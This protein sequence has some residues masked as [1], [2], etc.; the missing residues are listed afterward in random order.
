MLF[1]RSLSKL[2][3]CSLAGHIA[4]GVTITLIMVWLKATEESSFTCIGRSEKA[5]GWCYSQY[6]TTY[7]SPLPYI[8]FILFNFVSVYGTTF[9]FSILTFCCN[10]YDDKKASGM[11]LVFQLLLGALFTFLQHGIFFPKWFESQF[12]CTFPS[13]E[14]Q[15]E[16]NYTYAICESLTAENKDAVMV[17]VSMVNVVVA[18]ISLYELTRLLRRENFQLLITC[19]QRIWSRDPDDNICCCTFKTTGNV[20]GIF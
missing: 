15:Y 4:S 3:F 2:G 13:D 11:Y 17:I 9:V 14:P 12:N 5:T 6:E 8:Y 20:F 16:L 18:L 1:L 19:V 7:E 10:C